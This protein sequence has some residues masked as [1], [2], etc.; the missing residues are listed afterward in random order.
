MV[1]RALEEITKG[2]ILAEQFSSVDEVRPIYET[3]I[4]IAPKQA[5]LYQQWAIFE[6][7]HRNRS[8]LKADGLAATAHE[9]DDRNTSIIHTQL[10]IDR[11]RANEETSL[12][13]KQSLRR[14]VRDRLNDLPMGSRFAVS[15]RCK[16]LV[17]E[18]AELSRSLPDKPKPHEAQFFAEKVRDAENALAR[19]QQ[20]FDDDADIIQV[21]ARLRQVLDQEDRALRALQRAWGA[22]PKGSGIASRIAKILENRDQGPDALLDFF[23][24]S[25][26]SSRIMRSC[27]SGSIEP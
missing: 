6:L 1:K 27:V 12:V 13:L 14:R 26:N 20:D 3:A 11:K 18:V 21:E 4:K 22:G 7:N 8:T 15:S 19:A 24:T 17:D 10:E 9:M 5:F 25:K 2:R 16:L 23:A